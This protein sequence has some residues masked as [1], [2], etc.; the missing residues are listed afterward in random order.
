MAHY[1]IN[2]SIHTLV[3]FLSPLSSPSPTPLPLV[4]KILQYSVQVESVGV[5]K[6]EE[7][8]KLYEKLGDLCCN[9]AIFTSA[10]KF[11]GQQVSWYECGW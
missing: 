1:D 8:L 4:R 7:R 11:Y 3:S 9:L 6:V 10:V 2:Y 5:E